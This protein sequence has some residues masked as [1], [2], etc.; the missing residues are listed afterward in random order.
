MIDKILAGNKFKI[1]EKKFFFKQLLIEFNPDNADFD[2]KEYY[3]KIY[4][5]LK[6]YIFLL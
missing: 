5:Y 3:E 1:N 2:N 4:N 6:N